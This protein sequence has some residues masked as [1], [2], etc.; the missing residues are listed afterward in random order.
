VGAQ[1]GGHHITGRPARLAVSAVP[2]IHAPTEL[3]ISGR[4]RPS[5]AGAPLRR[6]K[7]K[8]CSRRMRSADKTFAHPT[9]RCR[10]VSAETPK[11]ERDHSMS[12]QGSKLDSRKRRWRVRARCAWRKLDCFNPSFQWQQGRAVA[13]ADDTPPRVG[14]DSGLGI[15]I[16]GRRDIAPVRGS[17]KR[18]GRLNAPQLPAR[19][20]A[21]SPR[22]ARV[23][24]GPVWRQRRRSSRMPGVTPGTAARASGRTADRIRF[25][26]P[27]RKRHRPGEGR[28]FTKPRTLIERFC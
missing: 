18:T 10:R 9:Y 22:A 16:I 3:R 15:R 14:S 24:P 13:K 20:T 28:Q 8:E 17:R 23:R 4:G 11:G 12:G 19:V 25:G 27:G 21:G 2:R 1:E 26:R 7:K 6:V 5:P